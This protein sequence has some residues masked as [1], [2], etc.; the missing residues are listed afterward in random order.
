MSE[1]ASSA[2]CNHRLYERVWLYIIIT[3]P[4]L[5]L[6]GFATYVLWLN[7]F[8]LGIIYIGFYVLT[9]IF[10]SYYCI[11]IDCPYIGGFCPAVAGI[12]PAAWIARI[13]QKLGL[14]TNKK[15]AEVAATLGATMLLGLIVFPLY[16]L[17]QYNL[18]AFFGFLIGILIYGFTFLLQICPVCASKESCPGGITSTKLRQKLSKQE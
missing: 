6:M 14:K 10:Q 17:F 5:A 11:N 8:W 12:M 9:N 7:K 15:I 3:V 13:L 16:W 1:E 18:I 2:A 4:L